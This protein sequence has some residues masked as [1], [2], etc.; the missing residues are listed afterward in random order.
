MASLIA[1]FTGGTVLLAFSLTACS[2]PGIVYR[3]VEGFPPDREAALRGRGAA[4]ANMGAGGVLCGE[5][6]AMPMTSMLVLVVVLVVLVLVLVVM[7]MLAVMSVLVVL[8]VLVVV[9]AVVGGCIQWC[10]LYNAG[11]PL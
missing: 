3:S 11:Y 4:A 5:T 10:P 7:S 8:V 6:A 2:D 1:S 9:L